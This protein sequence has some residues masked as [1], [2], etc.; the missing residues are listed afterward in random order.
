M[1]KIYYAHH[2]QRIGDLMGELLDGEVCDGHTEIYLYYSEDDE[3]YFV[4]R[5]PITAQRILEQYPTGW[6]FQEGSE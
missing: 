3:T 2:D 4:S 1:S 6:E 5:E